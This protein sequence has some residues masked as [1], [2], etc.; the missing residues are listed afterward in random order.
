MSRPTVTHLLGRQFDGYL[1]VGL[2][3]GRDAVVESVVLDYLGA[4]AG[5]RRRMLEAVR[6]R[7]AGVLSAYG[8]RMAAIAVRTG[9]V[10][11]L[12]RAVVA[13]GMADARLPDPRDNLV[14]LAAVSH[15][16]RILGSTLSRILDDVR[17]HLPEPAHATFRAFVAGNAGHDSLS[18]MGLAAYGSTDDFRYGS[19]PTTP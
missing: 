10:L 1:A 15:S 3:D 16:A 6:P 8:Q 17:R 11:P 7:A 2:P 5:E 12:R 4:P 13:L 14:V 19:G 9:S 18:A